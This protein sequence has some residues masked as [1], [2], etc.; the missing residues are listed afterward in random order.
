MT[1]ETTQ[2]TPRATDGTDEAA[3]LVAQCVQGDD[4][5]Q[6]RFYAAYDELIR[7]AVIRKLIAAGVYDVL[8]AD[9]DDMCNEVFARVFAD[10][11]RLLRRLHQP[12]SLR[13]WLMTVAQHHAVDQIRKWGSRWRTQAAARDVDEE[14]YGPSPET[15]AVASERRDLLNKRL[16]GLAH[17]ER[18]VLDL[19]Y[20]QGLKHAEMAEVLGLNINTASARLRRAKAKLRSLLEEDRHELTG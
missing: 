7:C 15:H 19:F 13:A 6:A 3:R 8:R 10:D 16:A 5:A 12:R 9:V 2:A 4:Q 11:C 20:V 17:H 18:L 14:R 1:G